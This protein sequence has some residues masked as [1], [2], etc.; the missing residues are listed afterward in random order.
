DR[1]STRLNSSHLV[2]S[3]AVFCL[4]KNIAADADFVVDNAGLRPEDGHALTHELAGFSHAQVGVEAYQF[5]YGIGTQHFVGIMRTNRQYLVSLGDKQLGHVGEVILAVRI[6]SAQAVD[7]R[8][9]RL[10]VEG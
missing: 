9:E 2:I 7:V 4:K 1:K 3:Y 6:I 8:E 5:G 10:G